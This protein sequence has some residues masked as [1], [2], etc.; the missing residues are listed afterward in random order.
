LQLVSTAAAALLLATAPALAAAAAFIPM[1]Q[2]V[3][4]VTGP[5]ALEVY[6]SCKKDSRQHTH[7]LACAICLVMGASST[8]LLPLSWCLPALA[9]LLFLFG[10]T[11]AA[12]EALVYIHVAQRLEVLGKH[13]ATNVSMCMYMIALALGAGLGNMAGG[14]LHNGGWPTQVGVMCGLTG[15]TSVYGAV[16]S[17]CM[18]GWQRQ[19]VLQQQ[20]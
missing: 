15:F 8:L 14:A 9:C 10:L 5:F 6:L 18:A 11:Q 13:V 20:A 4:A 3:G 1:L 2:V 17:F 12:T 19:A 7:Y 16:L